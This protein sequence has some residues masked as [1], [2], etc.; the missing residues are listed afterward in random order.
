VDVDKWDIMLN[1]ENLNKVSFCGVGPYGIPEIDPVTEYP[2][3]DFIPINFAKS[4]KNPESKNVHCFVDD[5]QFIRYWNRPDTYI[6]KL[7]QFRSICAP[8]FST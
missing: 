2:S 1:F 8:D 5:Y 4:E 6:P 7:R 3:G